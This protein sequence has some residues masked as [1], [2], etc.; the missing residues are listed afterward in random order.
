MSEQVIGAVSVV[1]GG[2]NA[3]L[4]KVVADT[5][6]LAAD[7]EKRG[8]KIAITPQMVQ[9]AAG[10]AAGLRASV[11]QVPLMVQPKIDPGAAQ[12]LKAEAG[13][14]FTRAP[15]VQPVQVQTQPAQVKQL[16]AEISKE[17]TVPLRQKVVVDYD[18]RGGGG[19][20]SRGDDGFSFDPIRQN[21]FDLK[22]LGRAAGVAGLVGAGMFAS[23]VGGGVFDTVGASSRGDRAGIRDGV[24]TTVESF[25]QIPIIGELSRRLGANFREA[26][27]KIRDAV[28]FSEQ[29][30]QKASSTRRAMAREFGTGRGTVAGV[31][32]EDL[33]MDVDAA[34]REARAALRDPNSALKPYQRE[35]IQANI[36]ANNAY[37]GAA[38]EDNKRRGAGIATDI[39]NSNYDA[40]LDGQIRD[41]Q[42]RGDT[43]EAERLRLQRA[44]NAVVAAGPKL[45]DLERA[46]GGRDALGQLNPT[47]KKILDQQAIAVDNAGVEEQRKIAQEKI[48]IEQ[49]GLDIQARLA[50]D[51]LRIQGQS[52]EAELLIIN[53]TADRKVAL[54]Q[55]AAERELAEQERKAAKEV[56]E[57]RR[58][59]ELNQKGFDLNTRMAVADARMRGDDQAA[60]NITARANAEKEIRNAPDE[61]RART[62][63]VAIAELKAAFGPKAIDRNVYATDF[64][65]TRMQSRP[66][67]EKD[68]SEKLLADAVDYLKNINDGIAGLGGG[69]GLG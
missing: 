31:A 29:A 40:K 7:L 64:D 67:G 20:A 39:A 16:K 4:R 5:K 50:A 12:K 41:A 17:F 45:E 66:F 68:E 28:A 65:P 22:G 23:K 47:V 57:L 61:L 56:A 58:K 19:R 55:T 44:R 42:M 27:Q 62:R 21:I 32:L 37:Y 33:A 30:S 14:V 38:V 54:A 34:N 60:A 6:S 36:D 43:G 48:A 3:P 13:V 49:D 18:R 1:I 25:N 8:I 26:A 35:R 9:N 10:V 24:A 51:K 53:R 69:G 52:A 63:E 15:I 46:F 2:D 11:G 59:D